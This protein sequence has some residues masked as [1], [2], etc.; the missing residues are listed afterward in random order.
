MDKKRLIFAVIFLAVT[1]LFIYL[2]YLVFFAKDDGTTQTGGGQTG[3]LE[4]GLSTPGANLP[5]AGSGSVDTDQFDNAGMDFPSASESGNLVGSNL[6]KAFEITQL[7]EA[8]IKNLKLNNLG[9]SNFYNSS[10]GKFYQ[11]DTAGN[12]KEL[13]DTTFYNVESVT[14]SPNKNESIIEYPDGSNIYYNFD[15]KKQVTLPEHWED[16]S[17]SPQGEKIASKS[18]GLSPENRW[19]ISSDPTGK[20]V[21]LIGNLNENQDRVDVDW[22]PN[23][24]I[25][26]FSRT[27]EAQGA[28]REEIYLIGQNDENFKSL[29]VEGRNFESTWS[30]S[31]EKLLYSVY[32]SE[33]N[34]EPELWI[35]NSSGNLIGSGR[36]K[37]NLNTWSN[38]CTFQ[39]DR[40]V[41]CAVP[42]E[43]ERGAGIEPTL[44]DYIED[45]IYKIDTKTGIK[46]EILLNE[47]HVIDSMYLGN[48]DK[49]YFTDKNQDGLFNIKI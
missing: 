6:P 29:I 20:N 10:D 35:V 28:D 5:T 11:L 22:S 7:T 23:E 27:G 9:N 25:V 32:S 42:N 3:I 43:M 39:D 8:P 26:A 12:L 21:K 15:T 1:A 30:P 46:T 36:K 24:Q 38:K 49:I 16:F 2:M 19:L 14:W 18:I 45:S 37:L 34:F 31:G 41:Y 33:S 47:Y 13:S 44:V 48:D 4:P 40:F 17:F